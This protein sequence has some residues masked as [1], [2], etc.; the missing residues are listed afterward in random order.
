MIV[1]RAINKINGKQY[2]GYTTKSLSERIQTHVNKSRSN[3][4]KSYFYL[5]KLALRK[6]KIDNTLDV[7]IEWNTNNGGNSILSRN[8]TLTKVY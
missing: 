2:I 4:D 8:F 7:T 5:F 6:Y 3:S 1:Y